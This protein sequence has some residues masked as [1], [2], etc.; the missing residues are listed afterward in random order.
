M[1]AE[2]ACVPCLE[3]PATPEKGYH[4]FSRR[5]RLDALDRRPAGQVAYVVRSGPMIEETRTPTA[6]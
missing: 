5:T 1:F 2:R 4:R 6:G 3:Q